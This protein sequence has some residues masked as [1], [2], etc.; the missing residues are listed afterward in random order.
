MSPI[1][2]VIHGFASASFH[3]ILTWVCFVCRA[4]LSFAKV[5]NNYSEESDFMVPAHLVEKCH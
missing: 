2:S 3:F 1:I 5:A 4:P